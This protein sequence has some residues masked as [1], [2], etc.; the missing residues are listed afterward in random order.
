MKVKGKSTLF[1]PFVARVDFRGDAD[2][3]EKIVCIFHVLLFLDNPRV[4][5]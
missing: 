1:W 5:L 3:L 2:D 4:R